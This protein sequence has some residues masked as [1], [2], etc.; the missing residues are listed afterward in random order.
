LLVVPQEKI[1]VPY[2][3]MKPPPTPESTLDRYLMWNEIALNTTAIDHTPA[4]PGGINYLCS[5]FGSKSEAPC[6]Q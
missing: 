2:S 3:V 1:A 6:G 5:N 4:G